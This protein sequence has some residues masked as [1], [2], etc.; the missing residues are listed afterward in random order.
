MIHLVDVHNPALPV[1]WNKAVE[2]P[3]SDVPD[4]ARVFAKDRWTNAP[5]IAGMRVGAGAV[6]WVAANPGTT[7][8]E[9]F[10][11]LMQ[12]LADLG[13]EPSFRASNLWAFF[14]DSYRTRADP[15]YLA[16]RWR[17]AGIAAIH[18]ASWHFYDSDAA[19]DDYLKLLIEACHRHGI[20]VYAWS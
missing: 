4:A 2:L 5:V 12:A 16:A 9:R 15:D 7:G 18:V 20:L 13:F 3:K 1:I 14:D 6:L 19:H 11:Y 17:N 8:Y 10:P